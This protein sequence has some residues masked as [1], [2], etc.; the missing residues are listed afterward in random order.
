MKKMI[1]LL[2]AL[3][4]SLAFNACDNSDDDNDNNPLNKSLT[5]AYR[6][7]SAILPTAQDFDNDGDQ[8]NNAVLEGPCYNDSWISFHADGTYDESFRM[9]TASAGS[10]TTGCDSQTTS[11]TY[12]VSGNT[13]TTVAA[14]SGQTKTFTFDADN[15]TVATTQTNMT[16]PAWNSV[17]S[18]W[19]S[20]SGN[21]NITFTKY[22]DDDED[23]GENADNDGEN[24]DENNAN[25]W[26]LG[27]FNLSSFVAPSAQNLDNDGDNSSNLVS[28][29]SCY[30]QSYI[31][32]NADG[33]YQEERVMP[34]I[35]ANLLTLSCQTQT[36][37]GT[38]IRSGNTITTTR[39]SSG[40]GS[41]TTTYN[42]DSSTRLLT[43]TESN[44][45]F[46]SFNS[47]T[48]LFS[49]LSGSINYTYTRN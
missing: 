7:T 17:T 2:F 42:F 44:G 21:V 14:G 45:S 35:S 16:Y 31:R 22:T 10:I 47:G 37:S 18:L 5:G 3:A 49:M 12:T 32:F 41:A 25:F 28:E 4:G 24:D 33:T 9:S 26:L 13:V 15:R 20:L 48:S 46:P 43:R 11:G 27:N 8:S 39:T 36:I 40:S 1:F 19:T 30:G 38:W 6:L 23:N 29:S 34:T